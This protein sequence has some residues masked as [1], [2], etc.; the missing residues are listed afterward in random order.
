MPSKKTNKRND[1]F[2][3]MDDHNNQLGW[4][5]LISCNAKWCKHKNQARNLGKGGF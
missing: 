5:H 1:F 2:L 3:L 4:R